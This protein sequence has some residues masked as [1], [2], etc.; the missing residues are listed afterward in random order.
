MRA[1]EGVLGVV[2]VVGAIAVPGGGAGIRGLQR[3]LVSLQCS[4]TRTGGGDELER[5]VAATARREDARSA[6][7]RG[8]LW[9]GREDGEAGEPKLGRCSQRGPLVRRGVGRAN[10]RA[11]YGQR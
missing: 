3:A 11:R 1:E 2:D 4:R 9:L 7:R 10:R 5:A 8:G 6:V